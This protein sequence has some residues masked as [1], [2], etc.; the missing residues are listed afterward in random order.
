MEVLVGTQLNLY[1]NIYHGGDIY[2]LNQSTATRS[3]T[4]FLG[5]Q[6]IFDYGNGLS[7]SQ[8]SCLI[9]LNMYIYWDSDL[10][11]SNQFTLFND[12][13]AMD[14]YLKWNYDTFYTQQ[15]Q[16]YLMQANY[17]NGKL[18]IGIY[19]NEQFVLKSQEQIVTDFINVFANRGFVLTFH[20]KLV[21]QFG[22]TNRI[23]ILN[24]IN[25]P[26]FLLIFNNNQ[27]YLFNTLLAGIQ[28]NKWYQVTIVCNQIAQL[29]YFILNDDQTTLNQF[30]ITYALQSSQLL[31]GDS[32]NTNYNLYLNYIRVYEGMFLT[33]SS[34]CFMLEAR[35]Q[36]HCIIC[37]NGYLI[38]YQNSM[39]CVSPS[40]SNQST[41][42]DNV[43]DWFPKQFKCPQNMILN[44]SNVCVCMFQYYRV[45]DDCFQ[46][47]NYCRGCLDADTCIKMDLQRQNNGKCLDGL[48][49]DGYNCYSL[50]YNIKSRINYI[51]TLNPNNLP[52]GCAQIGT[53]SSYLIDNSI[54]ML[55]KDQ[56]F[57]F[58]FS[59]Q[60][61]DAVS[62][63]TIAFLQDG[64]SELFTIMLEITSNNG[65]NLPSVALYVKGS[66]KVSL[67]IT[68]SSTVWI[69]LWTNFSNVIFFIFSEMVMQQQ[70]V[71]ISSY[72][73][74]YIVQ[75]PI[76][77]VGKCS[78]QLEAFYA[79]AMYSQ[80]LYIYH[81]EQINDPTQIRYLMNNF[82]QEISFF[83]ID[84]FNLPNSNSI[85]D[86]QNK[87]S[88]ISNSKFIS[89]RFKGILF[90]Q[91][92]N[93]QISGVDILQ[94][95]PSFSCY[96]F[97]EELTFQ[98]MIFQIQLG[99]SQLQYYIVPYGTKALVRI[100]QFNLCLDTKYS[101][102][103]INEQN[104]LYIIY[105]NKGII[106]MIVYQ[107]FE[108]FCN[109][110]REV[111]QFFES[112]Q[113]FPASSTIFFFNQ[114]YLSN[115]Q[116]QSVYLNKIRIEVGE[117]FYYYD[118][119]L[120]E[121]CFL[122]RNIEQMECLI[123]KK[124]FVFYQGILLIT[125]DECNNLTI[126]KNSFHVINPSTQECINSYLSQYCQ[127]LDDTSNSAKCKKC[128]Y[129]GQNPSNNC[130]CEYGSYF[131]FSNLKCQKCSP[132][133]QTCTGSFDNCLTCK[134]TNQNPPTC[135]CLNQNEYL[136]ENY[137]CKI[138]SSKCQT[139]Y[140]SANKCLTCSKNRINPPDCS[141][142]FQ[143]TEVN[144]QC[145]PLKCENKCAKCDQSTSNCI[146]CSIGRVNPPICN[147]KLNYIENQDG[148]CPQCI[149]GNYFD[150]KNNNCQQCS[151][152]CL[153][154]INYQ[155]NCTSCNFGLILK[156]DKCN[157]QEGT[158]MIKKNN[159]ILCLKN[160]NV[161]LSVILNST[162]YSLVFKFDYNIQELNNQYMQ[163]IGSLIQITFQEVPKNLYEISDPVVQGNTV[164]VKLNIYKSFQTQQGW[165]QFLDNTHFI[166]TS[167]EFVLDQKYTINLIKFEIGPF[168]FDKNVM[169]GGL[170]DQII[171]QFQDSSKDMAFN[172]IKQFQ[173]ILYILNTAQPSAL[174]LL[175]NANL[176]PNLYKFYQV[177]GL[178]VYPDV[179]N[180]QSTN[181][182]QNFQFFYMNLNQTEV[183]LSSEQ[184]YKK[185]GFCNS[186]LINA[187]GVIMKYSII[188]LS[189]IILQVIL[190]WD[191]QKVCQ[192]NKLLQMKQFFIKRINSENDTNLLLLFQSILVQFTYYDDQIWAVRYGY[193]LA[194]LFL[195][196]LILSFY[197]NVK[198]VNSKQDFSDQDFSFQF[199]ER[200]LDTKS[201]LKRNYFI[202]QLFKKYLVLII[203]FFF[204]EFPKQVCIIN[205]I[206]FFVSCF[207]TIFMKP[208][209]N[210][211]SRI[212]KIIGDLL[213]SISWFLHIPI[214][215]LEKKF[216]EEMIINQDQIQ[217]YLQ[218]GKIIIV[219]IIIFNILFL[220]QKIIE[221]IIEIYHFIFLKTKN[222]QNT[223][224]VNI[225][226][227]QIS[228][229]KDLNSVRFYKPYLKNQ[230]K[231]IK[232]K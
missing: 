140:Q 36:Q 15:N 62:K 23:V 144:G 74:S 167:Q 224:Q 230:S 194:I 10:S 76:L 125:E 138:C 87:Y 26:N 196:I 228:N 186:F 162:F 195:F 115:L 54:L 19:R 173:I 14:I 49:D 78:S 56:G 1:A 220:I 110:Q 171:N 209:K 12:L 202:V 57:F 102:L 165:V 103:N 41:I 7:Y 58:S 215:V 158:S 46:C 187:Q 193:Y 134:Y 70:S 94:N 131:N 153:S 100:C 121:K 226:Q 30:I 5:S 119:N 192:S 222:D 3:Q 16:G 44:S 72:F 77:C 93:A 223:T 109:Y 127:Q 48:F 181:Y 204:R 64:T 34:S 183:F 216:T 217:Q 161:Y 66:K 172:F 106:S 174:F 37:K 143:Y 101:M 159:Q 211:I 155:S 67:I 18:P 8:Y 105:R 97:I 98:Q 145:Q 126:N 79:C 168:L 39:N 148:T 38:D 139:C 22:N 205:G 95:Y 40:S 188:L 68:L 197:L 129:K 189:L 84:F 185:L 199:I 17:P 43:R 63:A 25:Y 90:T 175:I 96:I 212:V 198:Q 160:M 231:N 157:C 229:F 45:G 232:L 178:L 104:F 137:I 201:T 164:K 24:I 50:K 141:C 219:L 29:F 116:K 28:L 13:S 2:S 59:V 4:A 107:E 73:S 31:F 147:C 61:Y 208:Y 169:D 55:Q 91:S 86:Q 81:L 221:V 146:E 60:V 118:Q 83:K 27:L 88:L 191:S 150:Q 51:K 33:S 80:I 69:G 128:Q 207:S 124:G 179:V 218:F 35:V 65:Y 20:F 120:S 114:I 180:Y 42:I 6:M 184:V 122:F 214:I 213:I 99:S 113:T 52:S 154:C 47:K 21:S 203:L 112:Q 123:P 117:G 151:N 135:E 170:S 227:Q 190:A 156:N 152:E 9:I 133:C 182:K 142:A 225:T 89:N 108:I 71:N 166:S 210:R 136:D 32:Y 132:Q 75:N 200:L 82:T 11:E 130:E 176:P 92:L 206:T 85:K 149:Q 111:L 163:N 53:Q 177:I